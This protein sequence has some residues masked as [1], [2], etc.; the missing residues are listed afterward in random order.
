M[1]LDTTGWD[2]RIVEFYDYWFSLANGDVPDRVQFDPLA[3]PRLLRYTWMV[4]VEG[5][6]YRFKFRLIGSR[7]DE[8]MEESLTGR[9]L[10]EVYDG[11]GVRDYELVGIDQELSYRRGEAHFHV[12]RISEIERIMLPVTNKAKGHNIILGFTI[13]H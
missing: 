6:P 12:K 8:V 3:I 4:D 5:P 1:K 9:Y 11:P 2:P 10:D 7:H 13:Y